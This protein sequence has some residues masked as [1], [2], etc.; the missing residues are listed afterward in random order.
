M[1]FPRVGFTHKAQAKVR[2]VVVSLFGSRSGYTPNSAE[3]L[4][5]C[6]DL[7]FGKLDQAVDIGPNGTVLLSECLHDI[8]YERDD[9]KISLKVFL[10]EFDFGQ[11]TNA[12]E[13]TLDQ[14]K[15][16]S[17]E[18]IIV[19]FPEMEGES[20]EDEKLWR[21]NLI[22]LWKNI[23]SLVDSGKVVS[24]GVADLQLSQLEK[25]YDEAD[26][27]PCVNHFNIDG[28]CVVPPE[29]QSFA[30]EHDIQ[31]LTHNDPSPFPVKEVFSSVCEHRCDS[32]PC[33]FGLVW[34]A[35]YTVWVQR[36]SIMASKGYIIQFNEQK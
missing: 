26:V 7:Q 30:R 31:L 8:M 36:R 35:R 15:T 27:K 28:C 18:Q 3:E 1:F 22:S 19:A 29:L 5:A 32:Q 16:D 21:K 12:I 2:S 4:S 33:G 23:E 11:I 10:T 25:L 34:A 13:A 20:D 9:L 24:A 6:L 14:L 17:I